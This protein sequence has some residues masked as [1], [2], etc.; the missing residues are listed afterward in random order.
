MEPLLLVWIMVAAIGL[1][2]FGAR[3][4][5][6]PARNV[7]GDRG[8]LQFAACAA[9][10]KTEV[11]SDRPYAVQWISMKGNAAS[12]AGV[13]LS[14]EADGQTVFATP[15]PVLLLQSPNAVTAVGAAHAD[16]VVCFVPSRPFN[17]SR[18]LPL[19]FTFSAAVDVFVN[20]VPTG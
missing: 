1:A 8:G 6:R 18:G 2:V 17:L 11:T 15:C 4:A 12:L 5:G 13:T 19:K 7:A 20:G 9:G 16:G 10:V 14:L 3:M